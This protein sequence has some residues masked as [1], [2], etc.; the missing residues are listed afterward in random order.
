[1]KKVLATLLAGVL[2]VSL[3]ACGAAPSSSSTAAG[4]TAG[5]GSAAT[6]GDV[7]LTVT[8]W[9]NQVRNERTQAA[10][11]LYNAQNPSVTFDGQFAEWGDYWTKLATASAGQ[12]LPDLVQM[13]Y[14][15]L[16]QYVENGLLVD[17][18]PYIDSGILDVSGIDPGILE[19]GSID[20]GVYAICLGVNAPA[21]MY[22]KTLLDANGITVK[23]NMT[24]AEF[25][26]LSQEVYEKTGVKTDVSY[27]AGENFIDYTLRS[28]GF[29][30]YN[31]KAFGVESATDFEPYFAIYEKGLADGWLI[32]PEVFAERTVG[33]IEQNPI[34]MGSSPETRSWC[35]FMYSNQLT[36][37][38]SAADAE[39]L[40]IGMTTWP[41]D[42]TKAANYLKPSQFISVS[43]HSK[44]PE[45][46]AKVIDFLTNSIECNEILLA[47]RGVPASAATA[48]ALAPK[49]DAMQQ[50]IIAYINEV[51]TPNCSAISAA[52]PDSSAEVLKLYDSIQE[53]VCYGQM[54]SV[55]AAK[56]LFEEGNV[57]LAS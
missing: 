3:A 10:L 49:L 51:V 26:A 4:S 42:D 56:K 50:G 33:T 46:A 20:G 14:K 7:A 2:A 31:G 38:Q 36:G 43:T 48:E 18:K 25:Y 39:S 35:S 17:L 52:A 11:D 9:G 21:L 19:A 27:G 40:E 16:T 44:N 6:G 5:A 55:D 30:L 23:D 1:M 45:E 22:N 57:I 53:Q 24:M 32:Q 54:N 41:A 34:V 28:S 15:Y 37:L 13:D 47:E 12:N 29:E 8:W